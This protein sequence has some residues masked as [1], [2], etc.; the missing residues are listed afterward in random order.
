MTT[1]LSDIQKQL[2]SI[3][4]KLKDLQETLLANLVMVGEMPAPTFQEE[5]RLA[6]VR[7]RLTEYGALNASGDEVGN[8]VGIIPGSGGGNRS[9]L[10]VAHGDTTYPTDYDPTVVVLPD[11]VTGPG[12]ADN[13]LGVAALC[14]LPLILEH[15]GIKLQSDL[16]LLASSRSLGKGNI[17]GA[18]FFLDNVQRKIDH[19]ICLEGAQLSRLSYASVG[20]FRGEIT[21][22]VPEASEWSGHWSESAVH[23]LNEVINRILE[24]PLPSRPYSS[25]VLGSIEGGEGAFNHVATSASLRFEIRSESLEMVNDIRD[26]IENIVAEV[27]SVTQAT[28][29]MRIFGHRDPGGLP[30][31]HPCQAPYAAI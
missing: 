27:N 9:I 31:A 11:R 18:R 25:V 5:N 1:T 20:M 21:C 2:P 30:F 16:V 6:F 15:L 26:R 12:I 14:T 13:A 28:A 23:A 8:S 29:S 22:S 24:I 19:G 17:E 4:T 3:A 10:L 7:D